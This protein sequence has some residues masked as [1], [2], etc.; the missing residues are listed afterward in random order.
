MGYVQSPCHRADRVTTRHAGASWR[1]ALLEPT[2]VGRLTLPPLGLVV[3]AA[4]GG[5]LLLVV[6]LDRWATPSDEH[7]YWLAARRLVDGLPIYDIAAPVGTPYAYWYPPPLAQVLAPFTLFASDLAFTAAWTV[8]LLGC[9]LLLADRRVLVALAM[10][11]FL[12]VAV[13]LWYRNVHIV[14]ALLIVLAL[15]RHPVFWVPAAAIKITPV[16]GLLYL[17]AARRYREAALVGGVGAVVLAIS[18]IVSPGAWAGFIDL[19]TTQGASA[20]ASLVPVPFPVRLLAAAAL[21]IVAGR[22]PGRRGEVLLVVALVI[23]N[24]TLW[25]TAFSLLVAVVPLMRTQR[26][27]PA[28]RP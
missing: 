11:A 12:P 3:L 17:L 5:A 24:P 19:V 15:R 26:V 7:A 27:A 16:L 20:G 6:A 23:G 2:V 4:I 14:L 22:I 10:V 9:L 28:L 13:E 8:L 1:R 21:V 25:M 18:V